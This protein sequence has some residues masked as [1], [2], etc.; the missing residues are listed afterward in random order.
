LFQINSRLKSALQLRT[1]DD[2]S[3]ASVGDRFLVNENEN[4]PRASTIHLLLNWTPL[5]RRE[6]AR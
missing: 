5:N 2:R 4:D 3:Y 1:S 6:P